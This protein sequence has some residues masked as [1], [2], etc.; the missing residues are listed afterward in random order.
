M[1]WDNSFVFIDNSK[2]FT[3]SL[4]RDGLHL[5]EI[6]NPSDIT[7]SCKGNMRVRINPVMKFS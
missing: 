6:E 3:S 4:F 7:E 2:I 5:L 1:S